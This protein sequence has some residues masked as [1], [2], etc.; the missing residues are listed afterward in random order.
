[1][2]IKW[3]GTAVRINKEQIL[4]NTY[5]S[6]K[7]YVYRRTQTNYNAKHIYFSQN[8]FFST[9]SNMIDLN[10]SLNCVVYTELNHFYGWRIILTV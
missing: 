7:T 5:L 3:H 9:L 1:M 4:L 10:C 8:A 2:R 6:S